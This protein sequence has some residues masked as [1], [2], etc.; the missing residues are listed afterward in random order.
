M[1]DTKIKT[2]DCETEKGKCRRALTGD[3]RKTIHAKEE[4]F[5]EPEELI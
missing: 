1:K 2:D 3:G 5:N 4:E